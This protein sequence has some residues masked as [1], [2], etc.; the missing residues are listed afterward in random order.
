MKQS[1]LL[2]VANLLKT[3]D[4]ELKDKAY[5]RLLDSVNNLTDEVITELIL[6]LENKDCQA[7][8]KEIL[9]R[10]ALNHMLPGKAQVI[11]VRLLANENCQIA[12]KDI[13]SHYYGLKYTRN[14]SDEAE[15]E[16]V[17]FL[18]KDDCPDVIKD[19]FWAY[20]DTYTTDC[21]YVPQYR[22]LSDCALTKLI[23]CLEDKE[24][25]NAATS[26]LMRYLDHCRGYAP[27][28]WGN[29]RSHGFTPKHEVQLIRLLKKDD[30]R[31]IA[32]ELLLKY[33]DS[34][35]IKLSKEAETKL[36]SL[37]WHKA[38]R[39]IAE[40]LL[41]KYAKYNYLHKTSQA[42]L[43]NLLMLAGLFKTQ[44]CKVELS[45]FH[46]KLKVA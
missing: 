43:D 22:N 19:F 16:L 45:C 8:A 29:Y 36:I 35:R 33:V 37:L 17:S 26:I 3:G 9:S 13:F 12:V 30:C 24:Y 28:F 2:E 6:L 42:C 15:I 40:E 14:L 46:A 34:F 25:R 20:V 10:R 5:Y 11:L 23:S 41:L 21:W 7:Y 32:K 18:L 44:T 4:L 31:D 39:N 1:S 38:H 27:G